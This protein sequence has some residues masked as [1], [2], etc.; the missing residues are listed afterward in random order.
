LAEGILVLVNRKYKR[1]LHFDAAGDIDIA[2]I[3]A[4]EIKTIEALDRSGMSGT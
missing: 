3:D 2:D 1:V 4:D